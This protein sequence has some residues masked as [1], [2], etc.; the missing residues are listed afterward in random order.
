MPKVKKPDDFKTAEDFLAYVRKT[1]MDDIS[2]DSY[3]RLAGMECSEFFAGKQWDSAM[4][5]RRNADGKPTLT[6]N[7]APAF[8]GQIVNNRRLNQTSIKVVPNTGGYAEIAEV[9]QGLIRSIEQ[10][11]K[12]SRA[13]DKAL[14]NC[15]IAGIG[16][17][18][19]CLEYADDDVFDQDIVIKTIPNPFSVIWD[20]YLTDH[21]GADA[22]HVAVTKRMS[23]DEFKRLYPD[24]TP[25]DIVGDYLLSG[26]DRGMAAQQYTD[27]HVYSFWR[28]RTVKRTLALMQD[29]GVRDITD[30]FQDVEALVGD[31]I[32]VEKQL[33]PEISALL[34]RNDLGEPIV[35]EKDRRYAEMYLLTGNSLLEGPYTLPISR[36][37]VFRVPGWEPNVGYQK[38]RYGL[39]QFMKDPMRIHNY[40][41]SVLVEKLMQAPKPRW[42][43]TASAVAGRESEWRQ[44][45]LKD[46]PLLIHN[47]D[48]AAPAF[49]MPVQVEPALVQISEMTVQDLKDVTNLHDASLGAVS[50]EVSGKAI[51]LRQKQGELA[52]VIYHDNLNAAIEECGSV[53]NQL[54]PVAYDTPRVIKIIGDDDKD[55]LVAINGFDE[56]AKDITLGKYST[57]IVTGPSYA[58]KRIEAV[59]SM[60]AVVNA[61]PDIAGVALDLIVKNLDWPGADD[62]AK[63]L[64]AKIAPEDAV[65][66]MSPEEQQAQQEAAAQQQAMQQRALELEMAQKE[67]EV[68]ERQGRAEQAQ[69]LAEQARASIQFEAEKLRL[70]SEKLVLEA[71]KIQNAD[72]EAQY[73]RLERLS[74]AED[75]QDDRD[76]ERRA[77]QRSENRGAADD[78]A[79]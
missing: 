36:V 49:T 40:F 27:V 25:G 72:R 22:S 26:V 73:S 13:Y 62:I 16:Q 65:E 56:T 6:I 51:G 74:I 58:T 59:E 50:N 43:A 48:T 7:R 3:N 20:R 78:N 77:K 46:D 39:I 34:A 19:V 23:Y 28:M 66:D 75:E 54:I 15:V 38:V 47:D 1:L 44:A 41:R 37:P 17:F 24:A 10:N 68:Q 31:K 53:I 52:T 33:N 8:V 71:E 61:A 5:A 32:D 12:A 4:E 42:V 64:R 63:R 2:S 30:D 67:A 9:R 79:S 11:S 69:A 14:E 60:M 29:G 35:R 18:E 57:T 70:E 55:L 21:T 45:H 76:E